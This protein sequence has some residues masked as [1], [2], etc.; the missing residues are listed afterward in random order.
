MLKATQTLSPRSDRLQDPLALFT[1]QNEHMTQAARLL[2]FLGGEAF[3][4]SLAEGAAADAECTVEV[5]LRGVLCLCAAETEPPNRNA[6]LHYFPS[7]A[8][9]R[10]MSAP[11]WPKARIWA[12]LCCKMQE[13]RQLADDG[14]QRAVLRRKCLPSMAR[15]APSNPNRRA[16][17]AVA[18]AGAA[19]IGAPVGLWGRP[20][21]AHA[22]ADACGLVH[23]MECSLP[24][25]AACMQLITHS[26]PLPTNYK[27]PGAAAAHEPA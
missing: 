5:R 18:G 16:R 3:L 11:C 17:P 15:L 2:S 8:A 13:V 12:S 9:C 23:V 22:A 4:G 24:L 21:M 19:A 10:S 6:A 1:S 14:V 27:T 7:T 20:A 25:H 26:T